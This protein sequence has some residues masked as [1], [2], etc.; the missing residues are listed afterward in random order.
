[1]RTVGD[2]EWLLL[3]RGWLRIALLL[4]TLVM[5]VLLLPLPGLA[6]AVYVDAEGE[7]RE[8]PSATREFAF[9]KRHLESSFDGYGATDVLAPAFAAIALSHLAAG[10]MNVWTA[11]RERQVELATLLDEV[12]RRSTDPRVLPHTLGLQQLGGGAA[13]DDHNLYL[14]HLGVILGV[15]RIVSCS[16]GRACPNAE[17]S[18]AMHGRIVKH[19]RDR[20]L[21]SPLAH[22]PSYPESAMWPADQAVTLLAL[23]LYDEIHETRLHEAP[24]SRWRATMKEHTDS[25]T[26]LFHS[27]V[28]PLGYATTPRGCALSWTSLYLAQV[29]PDVAREQY[30]LYRA[31]MSADVLG[32]GGF[33]EW[34][35]DRDQGG[36]DTDS[37]PILF[38][39]GM[40]ATGLGLGPARL[41]GDA[42]RYTAI[43]RAAL[44]FGVPS[45]FPSH[46]YGTAPILGEAIL[47][48]GRTA[49]SWFGPRPAPIGTTRTSAFSFPSLVLLLGYGSLLVLWLRRSL[50]ARHIAVRSGVRSAPKTRGQAA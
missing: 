8:A 9:A 46:G 48:H 2:P 7:W 50:A 28:S 5:L 23:R 13:L 14:S 18:D 29:A 34:P 36:M 32:L 41:F 43:R 17:A 15:R 25:A 27:S 10:L 16:G 37:G 45:V 35:T 38:G 20:T 1:M 42:D 24:L 19:L 30:R 47:F 11:E 40:A 3:R 6:G 22:A 26:G 21:D 12:A 49:R 31:Q 33:R 4:R 39:V 44:T